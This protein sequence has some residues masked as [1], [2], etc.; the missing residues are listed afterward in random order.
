M[1]TTA[2]AGDLPSFAER[3]SRAKEIEPQESPVMESEESLVDAILALD[4]L[5]RAGKLPDEAYQIRRAELKQ[6]LVNIRQGK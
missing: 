1:A 6:Q 5:H 4:D 3:V 2:M